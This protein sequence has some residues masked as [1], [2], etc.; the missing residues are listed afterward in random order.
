MYCGG[1][2]EGDHGVVP[3]MTYSINF[4]FCLLDVHSLKAV[5]F[6]VTGHAQQVGVQL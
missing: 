1:D 4:V 6:M 3:S 2:Q 5:A